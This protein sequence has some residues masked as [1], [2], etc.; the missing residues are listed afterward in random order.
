MLLCGV[1]WHERLANPKWAL[2]SAA[3]DQGLLWLTGSARA[4][5]ET[6]R[7]TCFRIRLGGVYLGLGQA[8]N[9]IKIGAPQIRMFKNSVTEFG[10]PQIGPMQIGVLQISS[11]QVG[12]REIG[13]PKIRPP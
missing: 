10:A 5:F 12:A 2:A 4:D 9:P 8:L 3:R 7:Q 1:R 11:L 6:S 13:V